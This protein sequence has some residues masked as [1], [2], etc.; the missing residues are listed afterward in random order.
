MDIQT[1]PTK[2]MGETGNLPSDGGYFIY[3]SHFDKSCFERNLEITILALL[4]L[5]K[6]YKYLFEKSKIS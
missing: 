3:D 6:F 4:R 1:I 5:F 2:K